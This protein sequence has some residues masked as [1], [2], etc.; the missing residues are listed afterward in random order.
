MIRYCMPGS[1]L[2]VR[3]SAEQSS[4]VPCSSGTYSLLAET[5]I[6]QISSLGLP[7]SLRLSGSVCH[8][9]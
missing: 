1:M 9:Q 5:D 3:C 8:T 4:Q 6:I 2:G 7:L